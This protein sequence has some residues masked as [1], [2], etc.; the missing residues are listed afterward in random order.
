[1]TFTI[2]SLPNQITKAIS[3]SRNSATTPRF[4]S[5]GSWSWFSQKVIKVLVMV[6]P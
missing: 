1:M 6:T 3:S 5:A 4:S 2:R